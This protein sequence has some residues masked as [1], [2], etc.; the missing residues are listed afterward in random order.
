MNQ[1][2]TTAPNQKTSTSSNTHVER[3]ID[4]M[5]ID[6]GYTDINEDADPDE[7]FDPEIDSIQTLSLDQMVI[8]DNS[9]PTDILK[10]SATPSQPTQASA[11]AIVTLSEVVITAEEKLPPTASAAQ[12]APSPAPK[13]TPPPA[14]PLTKPHGAKSE[15]PFLPQHILDKLS[16][17]RKDLA[18]DIVQSSASLDMSTAILRTHARAER[19]GKPN[20]NNNPFSSKDRASKEKQKLIDDL[21]D[22]YLPLMAAELRRRL[23]KLLEQ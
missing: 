18:D 16:Q 10:E 21:V 7:D 20:L 5:K 11:E 1:N 23:H 12:T 22:E 8:D 13:F 4:E 9:P 19:V 14:A 15:N 2:N 17:G 3:E 6:L